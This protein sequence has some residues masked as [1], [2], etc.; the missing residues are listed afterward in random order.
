MSSQKKDSEWLKAQLINL[1]TDAIA[2]D[3]VEHQ[4][5][6]KY[7]ELLWKML[8]K[9]TDKNVSDLDEARQAIRENTKPKK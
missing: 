8:P 9:G 2:R 4:A 1:L 5:C 3:P 6:A 7:A